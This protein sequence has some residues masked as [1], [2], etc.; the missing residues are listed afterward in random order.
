MKIT[1]VLE[2]MRPWLCAAL[3]TAVAAVAPATA[4][5][6]EA[7]FEAAFQICASVGEA[8]RDRITACTD[9]LDRDML[10][11]GPITALVYAL[12]GA[13]KMDLNRFRDGILDLTEALAIEPNNIGF[14]RARARAFGE[15]GEP[16]RAI[17]DID[18]AI[19]IA[20]EEAGLYVSR[21]IALAE[22]DNIPA[23]YRD[24]DTAEG[25]DERDPD[26]YNIRAG[27]LMAEEA[28]EAAA[29]QYTRAIALRPEESVLFLRRG[30]ALI[31]AGEDSLEDFE[32]AIALGLDTPEAFLYR[33]F[34][35]H[36]ADDEQGAFEDFSE[37]IDRDPALP[38]AWFR[39]G[40]IHME[41]NDY[42][43]AYRDLDVATQ[44]DPTSDNLNAI[45]WLLVSAEDV[46]F[47][48][49]EAA[50]DY[51]TRSIELDENADNVDTAAAAHALLDNQDK[52]MDFYIRSM[53]LGG[54]ERV[55]MYQEH[56]AERGYYTGVIDGADG[57][58]TRAAIKAFAEKRKVLLVD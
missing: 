27:I 41:R 42:D 20:P 24:L 15:M 34:A 9:L 37:V 13:A 26:V 5:T 23:A 10:D 46:D 6:P 19:E 52:A 38:V 44:V 48:N 21:A 55:R 31:S 1:G 25:L 3:M 2:T 28:F 47:R 29:E 17:Q 40:L 18:L 11:G 30:M 16:E 56:L 35:R 45:A 57:P 53:E 49:P 7:E 50:L 4:Q 33:A 51:V 32:T 58:L 22:M 8:P 43:A 12:R 39:R 54:E 14:L 36:A